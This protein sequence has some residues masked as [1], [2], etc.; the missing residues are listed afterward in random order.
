MAWAA[1]ALAGAQ[2]GSG[3]M[4]A[5]SGYKAG[6][7]QARSLFRQGRIYD[8]QGAGLLRAANAYSAS[9]GSAIAAG[10]ANARNRR[11][12][13]ARVDP[14]ERR[15]LDEAILARR[16]VIGAG[17]VGFAGNG[18]LL[19]GRADSA[20]AMWEQDEAAD[21]AYEQTII[22]QQAEDEV[23]DIRMDAN[24]LEA[25]GYASAGQFYGQAAQAASQA[26]SSYLSGSLAYQDAA[27]AKKAA[28]RSR[29]LGIATS[30]FGGAASGAASYFSRQARD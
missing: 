14:T 1:A 15:Q 26:F 22:M 19:E 27:A 13:V 16:Q 5:F 21:L 6:K 25:E 24:R 9:A 2:I 7:A 11:L 30:I 8:M 3:L 12:D 10:R 17:K 29:N 23:H 28:K 4:S 18:V 20:A